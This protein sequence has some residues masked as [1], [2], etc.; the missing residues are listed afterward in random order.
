MYI[1][2]FI[3]YLL[4]ILKMGK[5]HHKLRYSS[6]RKEQGRD[7]RCML[8][9]GRNKVHLAQTKIQVLDLYVNGYSWKPWYHLASVEKRRLFLEFFFSHTAARL[10]AVKKKK[11]NSIRLEFQLLYLFIFSTQDSVSEVEEL[12]KKHRDF[13]NMLAAQEEKFAQL[14]RKTKVKSRRLISCI[15][16]SMIWNLRYLKSVIPCKNTHCFYSNLRE[17]VAWFL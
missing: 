16:D 11:K 4:I 13:E 15:W 5:H 7:L 1:F 2:L 10:Q 14:S 17:A 9:Q 8:L 3:D 12:L 6:T